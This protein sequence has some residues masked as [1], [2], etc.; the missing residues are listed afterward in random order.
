M[1]IIAQEA[2]KRN[3]LLFRLLI[4]ILCQLFIGEGIETLFQKSSLKRESS[5]KFEH[6]L[7][8]ALSDENEVS[9]HEALMLTPNP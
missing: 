5:F 7:C 8:L 3:R 9:S 4:L 6:Q 1:T 2:I